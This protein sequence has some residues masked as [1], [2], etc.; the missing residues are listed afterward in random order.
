MEAVKCRAQIHDGMKA[1][2]AASDRPSTQFLSGKDPR[3]W[4][5]TLGR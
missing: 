1:S 5:K 4:T 3:G 2:P